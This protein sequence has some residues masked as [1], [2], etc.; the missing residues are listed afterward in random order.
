MSKKCIECGEIKLME[1]YYT[2][3][4]S[5]M[6][7]CITCVDKIRDSTTHII[8]NKCS[9]NLTVDNF[10]YR[11]DRKH[12]EKTCNECCKIQQQNHR[13]KNIDT[14]KERDR[15]YHITNKEHRNNQAA[16]YYKNNIDAIKERKKTILPR[17]SR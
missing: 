12:F 13:I 4:K 10:R 1:L 3:K 9:K 14:I 16:E 11:N 5:I 2:I 6:I 17:T 15:Q 7:R 8:C